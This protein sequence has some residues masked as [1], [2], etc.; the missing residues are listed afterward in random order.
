MVLPVEDV[1]IRV[2][3][4]VAVEDVDVVV[5]GDELVAG[6]QGRVEMVV[7]LVRIGRGSS[8]DVLFGGVVADVGGLEA[9]VQVNGVRREPAGEDIGDDGVAAGL[10]EP[11][12]GLGVFG[13]GLADLREQPFPGCRLRRDVSSWGSLVGGLRF[14]GD[15][16]HG[17]SPFMPSPVRL[18]SVRAVD[19]L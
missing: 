9:V 1:G 6:V 12:E 19:V 13:V 14:R 7:R 16:V 5:D 17:C 15:V 10:V 11:G 8:Q 3:G 2:C 4:L 18:G